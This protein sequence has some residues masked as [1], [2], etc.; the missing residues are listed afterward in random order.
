MRKS[1]AFYFPIQRGYSGSIQTLGLYLT[2]AKPLYGLNLFRW[3]LYFDPQIHHMRHYIQHVFKN[4]SV[5]VGTAVAL[6]VGTAVALVV[7][8]AVALVVG[9]AVASLVA[10]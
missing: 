4:Y 9:T 7:G 1:S 6:V 8:T 10:E 3:V 2:Q 5:V